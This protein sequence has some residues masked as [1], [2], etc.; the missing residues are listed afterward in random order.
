MFIE[1]VQATSGHLSSGKQVC[2]PLNI[3][4][5]LTANNVPPQLPSLNPSSSSLLPFYTLLSFPLPFFSLPLLSLLYSYNL[6]FFFLLFHFSL[7]PS[8]PHSSPQEQPNPAL[9]LVHLFKCTPAKSIFLSTLLPSLHTPFTPCFPQDSR[10]HRS[11]LPSDLHPHHIISP[12][13]HSPHTHSEKQANK[14]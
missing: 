13:T 6:K 14:T 2:V 7:P 8:Q 1:N 11:L 9:T 3:H 12:F 5:T 10:I 4:I